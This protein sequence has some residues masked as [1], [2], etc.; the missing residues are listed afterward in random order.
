MN[1]V[2]HIARA[3]VKRT[4]WFVTNVGQATGVIVVLWDVLKAACWIFVILLR[5]TASKDAKKGI[6][7]NAAKFVSLFFVS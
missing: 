7:I 6:R 2:N 3:V 1:I 5:G 4:R